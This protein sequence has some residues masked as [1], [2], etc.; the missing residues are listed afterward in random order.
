M[1]IVFIIAGI[2]SLALGILGIFLPLL[3]TVP[4]ILLAAACFSRGSKRMHV[5]LVRLPFAGKVIDDY[6]Q[7]RGVPRRAKITALLLLWGGMTSSAILIAPPWWVLAL[8][9]ATAIT[10]SVIILRLPKAIEP[11]TE[12]NMPYTQKGGV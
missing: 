2:V 6:E 7:G 8:L 9:A 12:K 11:G 1:R 3:P 4:F 5:W 10:A